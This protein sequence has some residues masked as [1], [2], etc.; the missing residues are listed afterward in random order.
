VLGSYPQREEPR[1]GV[2]ERNVAR[3][4][5]LG[6][7]TFHA[8]ASRFGGIVRQV[9]EHARALP[10]L[11]D[12]ELA[13]RIPALR[14]ALAVQG[15]ERPLVSEAFALVRE[16]SARTLGMRHY[17]VQV[18]GGWI[19]LRGMVAEMQTGEGKTLTAILPAATAALAGIPVHIV[20][21]ND[22]LVTR[23]AA[24][25][26]P[27]FAALGISVGSVTEGMEPGARREAYRCDVTYVTNKQLVFDY[28]RDRL[29]LGQVT[30]GLRMELE[31]LQGDAASTSELLM[32]GLC[33][34]IVDEADSVLVDEARTPLIIS[35]PGDATGEQRLYTQ[36]LEVARSLELGAHFSVDARRF[37]LDITDGGKKHLEAMASSLGGVWGGRQRRE[38][39]ARQALTALHLYH[40]DEQYLVKDDKVQIID[41]YT[42]RAM[43][44]RSWERGLHQLI[45]MKEGC[46]MTAQPETLARIS[47]QRFF[48]RYLRLAGM[49]GTAREVTAEFWA[50]YRLGVAVVG[51]NR[52]F[53][54]KALAEA[55][56][57]TRRAKL[58]A[59]VQRVTSL[60]ERGRPVLIGTR[61]VSASEAV[62]A[63][64]DG[65]GLAHSVLNARQDADEA[66][67]VAEAGQPGRI[68]V[69]TNMAGRGTDITLGPGIKELGGLHV[70]LTE[71][72]DA[73]RID[74]QLFGRCGRQG[75]PGSTESLTC[76]EDELAR[77]FYWRWL[78]RLFVRTGRTAR[79]L[80]AWLGRLLMAVPQW[81]AERRHESIRRELLTLD[82]RL[83][84][85]LAFSGRAE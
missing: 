9:N 18:L 59:L 30:G 16:L 75:D 7:Q 65:A 60:H 33:F 40:R 56:Y 63:E 24:T 45:E 29:T 34:A 83:N 10:A 15:F 42:G 46:E 61:S 72:H 50:V 69:A 55:V 51:T 71:R 19:L 52:P 1:I 25:M 17:D 35:R 38:E 62:S 14:E 66:T 81:A 6:R 22:Y 21:V 57:R 64:L 82:E 28:L 49:T 8:R 27:L 13:A 31:R 26:A 74:R 4:I 3:L 2:L 37:H 80:P 20:T 48:R 5:G 53:I 32:R 84:D 58:D 47:Y 39:L 41:E 79:P 78:L 11:A 36:A 70:I 77:D 44:D 12:D 54:R 73:R 85:M 67:V 68:T 43:P 76:L 23:D